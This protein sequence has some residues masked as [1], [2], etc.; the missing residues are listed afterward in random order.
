MKL[1]FENFGG[2]VP[3]TDPVNLPSNAAQIARN[4]DLSE[5][6]LKPWGVTNSFT[7]LHDDSGNMLPGFPA[8]DVAIITKGTKPTLAS[9]ANLFNAVASMT[10]SCKVFIVSP[11]GTE[12]LS[13]NLTINSIQMTPTG[14][15]LN[16]SIATGTIKLL[17]K[18]KE[19]IVNGPCYKVDFAAA[20]ATGGTDAAYAFPTALS[21]GSTPVPYFAVPLYSTA[22]SRA[23]YQ[24]G[25]LELVDVQGPTV[26]G[27]YFRPVDP[28]WVAEEDPED[29]LV[30]ITV[31]T[32]YAFAFTGNVDLFFDCNY[33]RNTPLR[34]YYLQQLVDGSG[35]DGPQSDIS[36][37]IIIQ[38][39]QIATLNTTASSKLYRSANAQSGFALVRDS[40][41]AATTFIEDYLHSLGDSLPAN[42]NIPHA[43]AALAVRGAIRHPAGF[44]VY[45]DGADLRPS[46]EWLDAPRPWAVPLEYAYTFDSTI[47]CIALAGDTIL[48][49][50][51]TA[52]YRAHGQHP[53][54]LALYEISDKPILNKLTLWK[55]GVQVGWCNVE[56]LVI[57][58]GGSGQLL[59]GE[60]M[61][62]DRWNAYTPA[63]FKARMNDKA[64]CLFDGAANLRFDFRGDRTA[65]ISTFTVTNGSA[66]AVW[67]SKRFDMPKPVSFFA[68]RIDG[69]GTVT[70]KLYADGVLATTVNA[71]LNKD[72][73]LPNVP[74]AWQWEV[75][76]EIQATGEVRRVGLATNRREL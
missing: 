43:S 32:Y 51:Q 35:R 70:M 15:K 66:P 13:S 73:L 48:V 20:V 5:G 2:I 60:Y 55:D 23:K 19:Y 24:Y 8:D 34:F 46:S 3:G 39:G 68:Y 9:V 22:N 37:E 31:T 40:A 38:P 28:P 65:A 59:T 74:K 63:N 64:V 45:Y 62:A 49:F 33:I 56:G 71:T 17:D 21:A 54:R 41:D 44:F 14:F 16:C 30:L 52:V 18:G 26:S 25:T 27:S 1:D 10:L 67:K 47:L 29:P 36:D 53:G 58:D 75:E 6:T 42:G 7:R 50:T 4:V 57:F 61:R 76:I 72:I 69:T 11:T 12:T